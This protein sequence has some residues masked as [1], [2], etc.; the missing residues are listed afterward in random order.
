MGAS[1]NRSERL[2]CKARGTEQPRHTVWV[3]EA[4]STAQRRNRAAQ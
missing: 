1:K 4:A 2:E 3:G